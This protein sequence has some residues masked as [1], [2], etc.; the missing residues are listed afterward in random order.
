MPEQKAPS[1]AVAVEVEQAEPLVTR[2]RLDQRLL[3]WIHTIAFLGLV[4]TG[5]P[6][7]PFRRL[8]FDLDFRGWIGGY[9][10]LIMS[11]HTWLAIGFISLPS[12]V[13]LVG[14]FAGRDG[15]RKDKGPESAGRRGLSHPSFRVKSLNLAKSVHVWITILMASAF[16]VTGSVM[17]ARSYVSFQI[18]EWSYYVHDILTYLSIPFIL[19]HLL[20]LHLLGAPEA[21]RGMITGKV[22]REWAESVALAP[23]EDK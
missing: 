12:A 14:W 8:P 20:V 15:L 10:N 21:M 16:A 7:L 9:S 22:R 6:L 19:G 3:H 1:M 13:F 17:W 5:I 23:L 2:Y 4:G 18:V 11:W